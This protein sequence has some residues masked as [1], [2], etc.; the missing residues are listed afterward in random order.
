MTDA[1]T[2][3][4]GETT[5]APAAPR[6]REARD[7]VVRARLLALRDETE[8]RREALRRD[9]AGIVEASKDSNA[10]DEH[11]PDGATIAF[12]RA[13]VGALLRLAEQQSAEAEAALARLDAGTYETCETCGGPVGQARLAVRPTARRCIACASAGRTAR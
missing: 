11:D 8:V 3:T 7:A 13:Q 5:V 9:V 6:E 10:D 1:D 12:E 2:G 4:P